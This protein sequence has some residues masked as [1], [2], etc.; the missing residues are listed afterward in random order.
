M[1]TTTAA[2]AAHD[3]FATTEF[4]NGCD[5]CLYAQVRRPLEV[6]TTDRDRVMANLDAR[7]RDTHAR[8]YPACHDWRERRDAVADA[9]G[10][11]WYGCADHA[12][13]TYTG[14]GNVARGR[15]TL[16]AAR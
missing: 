3:H 12:P 7:M 8:L 5:L 11:R 9:Q 10:W 16:R 6:T 2:R 13:S 15:E 14:I 1:H 4:S